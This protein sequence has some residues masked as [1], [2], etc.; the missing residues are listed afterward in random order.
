MALTQAGLVGPYG[1]Y[2]AMAAAGVLYHGATAV[3]G[4]AL[5]ISTGTA[6]TF[7]LWNTC[8]NKNAYLQRIDIGY[9]SGT[10]ALGEFGLANQACG[11]AIGTAAPLSA[12]T[13]GTAKNALLNQGSASAM[14]FIPATATL[15]TGGTAVKWLGK[16][17]ESATA[18]LG[19]FNCSYDF[20]GDIVVTPG[21]LVFVCGSVAQTGLF[22]CSMS[23][24]ELPV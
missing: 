11:Y 3:A 20:D 19:I 5:P 10:I 21:Q 2:A 23:W 9:T 18:G 17:I 4:V 14:T 12:V 22:T 24:A 15:S 1:K 8:A 13:S 7:G 16:S 6:V